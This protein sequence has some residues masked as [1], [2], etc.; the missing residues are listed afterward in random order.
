MS[1]EHR[2]LL[3]LLFGC[4]L[5]GRCDWVK[6]N[7][8]GCSV[9]QR[10]SCKRGPEYEADTLLLRAVNLICSRAH[11][12]AG[13]KNKENVNKF[14]CD[15]T[16]TLSCIHHNTAQIHLHLMTRN[17]K[18]IQ[19]YVHMNIR[20]Y[21]HTTYY[22]LVHTCTHI[23]TSNHIHTYSTYIHTCIHRSIYKH[24]HTYMHPTIQT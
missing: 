3:L 18:H 14:A 22:I 2:C 19:P 20:S 21:T 1:L 5:M 6:C 17:M 23:H 15:V 8:S 9:R 12:S 4:S 10:C 7:C 24:T 11:F 13:E 16:N